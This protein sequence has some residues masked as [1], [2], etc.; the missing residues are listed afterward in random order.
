MWIQLKQLEYIEWHLKSEKVCL[1]FIIYDTK[2]KFILI[3]MT[4]SYDIKLV[5]REYFFSSPFL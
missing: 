3:L 4:V 2:Q 5:I 1:C